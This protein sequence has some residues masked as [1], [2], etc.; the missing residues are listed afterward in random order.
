MKKT[1]KFLASGLLAITLFS[2]RDTTPH[3]EDTHDHDEVN[4]IVLTVTENGTNNTQTITYQTGS[5]ADRALSLASGK[6]YTS[7]VEFFGTHDGKEENMTEDIIEEKDEHFITYSFAGV[8][9][10]VTRTS[11][12]TER[13]DK[14]KLGLK[15]QWTVTSTP[16]STSKVVVGLVHGAKSVNATANNGGGAVEGG[17]TDAAA[18]IN[19]R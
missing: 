3:I 11:E 18:V 2:C 1:L 6:T 12:D 4:K 9:I 14:N 8:S 10:N 7:S 5:G 15:T 16:S 13:T 17:E 19:I